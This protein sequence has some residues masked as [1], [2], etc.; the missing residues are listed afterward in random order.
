MSSNAYRARD[1]NLRETKDWVIR[2]AQ[3]REIMVSCC[4]GKHVGLALQMKHDYLHQIVALSNSG[5]ACSELNFKI[6]HKN[7]CYQNAYCN[8]EILIKFYN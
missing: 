7:C 4:N 3:N 5:C 2:D 1:I 8:T 6:T